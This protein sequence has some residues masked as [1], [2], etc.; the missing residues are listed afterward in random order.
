[1]ILSTHLLA[2]VEAVCREILVLRKGELLARQAVDA[3]ARE[4]RQ[5]FEVEGFGDEEA[6]LAGLAGTGRRGA[7]DGSGCMLV[8]LDLTRLDGAASAGPRDSTPPPGVNAIL[9]RGRGHDYALRRLRRRPVSLAEE[10]YDMVE[11]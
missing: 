5:V 8:T 10:F 4:P 3:G 6:F 11:A 7:A 1:M 2:D 9:E